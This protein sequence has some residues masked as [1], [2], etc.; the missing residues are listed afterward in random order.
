MDESLFIKA[1]IAAIY[2]TDTGVED[3]PETDVMLAPET[4]Q[5]IKK[6]CRD[7][8]AL[9]GNMLVE[10]C[11]RVG[12]SAGHAGHDFWLTRNGHGAGFWCR[13][14]LAAGHLG[15]NLSSVVDS[16]NSISLYTGDDGLAYLA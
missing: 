16:F 10:A 5:L 9:A 4:L 15:A 7:F 6:D 14:E 8:I 3:Q 2:F 11:N 1:Y 13:D 12:Y